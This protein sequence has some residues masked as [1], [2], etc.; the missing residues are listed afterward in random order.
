MRS[1]L[2]AKG[3]KTLFYVALLQPILSMTFI[4]LLLCGSFYPLSFK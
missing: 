3:I 2:L 1:H 4:S